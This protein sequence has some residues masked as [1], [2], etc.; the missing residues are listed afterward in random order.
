MLYSWIN[1]YLCI[2][3]CNH[4]QDQNKVYFQHSKRLTLAPPI[5]NPCLSPHYC[6]NF[7]NHKLV[8]AYLE[9][10][11]AE[12]YSTYLIVSGF[13]H[14]ACLRESSMLSMLICFLMIC[15]VPQYNY[16]IIYPF[17]Y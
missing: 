9:F 1:L 6:P 5:H 7:Y 8:L 10:H 4:H 3:P 12:L 11:K 15:S 17:S 2:L 14:S 13:C 16:A